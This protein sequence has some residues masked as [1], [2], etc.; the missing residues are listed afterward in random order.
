VATKRLGRLEVIEAE[1]QNVDALA[2]S[3]LDWLEDEPDSLRR[4]FRIAADL[5][6]YRG[7]VERLAEAAFESCTATRQ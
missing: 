6:L 7:V 5:A 4:Y 1:L 2:G 3:L